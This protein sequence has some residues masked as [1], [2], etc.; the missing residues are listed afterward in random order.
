MLLL[1]RHR[2]KPL[3]LGVLWARNNG[4]LIVRVRSNPRTS[5]QY[6]RHISTHGQMLAH[7]HSV[8]LNKMQGTH[9]ILLFPVACQ[10]FVNRLNC[11]VGANTKTRTCLDNCTCMNK[12]SYTSTHTSKSLYVYLGKLCCEGIF[13]LKNIPV[14]INKR[15]L[16]TP[17]KQIGV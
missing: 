13:N 15:R 9:N 1:R 4:L 16:F 10:I 3:N 17:A 8:S 14:S 12:H 5:N 7:L 2:V 6:I 11:W